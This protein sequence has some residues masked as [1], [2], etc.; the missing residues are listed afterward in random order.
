MTAALL[1][2]WGF[3]AGPGHTRRK[4][5]PR[6]IIRITVALAPSDRFGN[7]TAALPE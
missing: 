2:G 3:A 1:L 4:V 7:Q 5:Q 6:L